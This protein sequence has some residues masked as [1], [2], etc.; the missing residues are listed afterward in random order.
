MRLTGAAL[1]ILAG[2]LLGLSAADDMRRRA[3]RRAGLT[4]MLERMSFELERFKTP[5]PALFDRLSAQMDGA[6]A[7]LCARMRDGLRQLPEG[8]APAVWAGAL[9]GLPETERAILLPLGQVLGRYGAGE[10]LLALEAARAAM[11]EAAAEARQALREKG[12]MYIGVSAAG[13]AAL[14]VLL[15]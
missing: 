5:L 2:L 9:E 6:A 1:L 12:R 7:V 14:A 8:G 13:A 3:L 4:A 11:A 10:Q 15:L